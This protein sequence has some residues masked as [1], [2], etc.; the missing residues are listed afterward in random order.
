MHAGS[1]ANSKVTLAGGSLS[2][3]VSLRPC[4]SRKE[5]RSHGS[6]G[7]W[8]ENPLARPLAVRGLWA[9]SGVGVGA[10]WVEVKRRRLSK[11]LPFFL[12][13]RLPGAVR[14]LRARRPKTLAP[15]ALSPAAGTASPPP[16]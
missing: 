9:G 1:D 12:I 14:S 3:R 11:T 10:A 15:A 4:N 16:S 6:R 5:R 2:R 8:K 7:G 13:A